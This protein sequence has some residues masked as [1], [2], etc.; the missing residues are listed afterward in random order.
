MRAYGFFYAIEVTSNLRMLG[1]ASFR[2][3]QNEEKHTE[4]DHALFAY[5]STRKCRNYSLST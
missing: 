4:N 2:R 5:E 1:F 3:R